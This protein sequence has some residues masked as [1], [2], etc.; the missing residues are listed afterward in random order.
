[1]TRRRVVGSISCLVAAVGLYFVLRPPTEPSY[2]GKPLSVWVDEIGK[3]RIYGKRDV[4][5]AEYR[6]AI[7]H[8]RAEALPFL[9]KW[10]TEDSTAGVNR[11]FKIRSWLPSFLQT[12]RLLARVERKLAR[13]MGPAYR[14]FGA[15][16]ALILLGKDA[17]PAVPALVHMFCKTSASYYGSYYGF[18]AY[19]SG[20]VL[21]GLGKEALPEVLAVLNDLQCGN[22]VGLALV[23]ARMQG[24]GDAAAAAVPMLCNGLQQ[25]NSSLRIDCAGALGNLA[26][27]PELSV[28]ALS[29]VLTNAMANGDVMLSRRCT[30]ALGKF[31][32]RGAAAVQVLCAALKSPDGITTEQAAVALGKIGADAPEAVPALI[33]YLKDGGS[34]HRRYAIEGLRG[35][36]D[37][38]QE[39]IPLIREALKDEDHD[40]RAM[41]EDTLRK[42]SSSEP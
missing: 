41:A 5:E 18:Q 14:A 4:P 29:G 16:G 30:D 24:I 8:M 25:T 34:R 39:A 35:Y 20:N 40:T 7:Q 28:P 36:A 1:M 33:A 23:V 37:V 2:Q 31:G 42:M 3:A 22:P 15:E 11:F 19:R 38:A 10:L 32:A 17:Q 26:L 13:R 9:L 27:M 6:E 21:A 12:S